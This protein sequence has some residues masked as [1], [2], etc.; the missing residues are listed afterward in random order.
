MPIAF[1]HQDLGLVDWMTVAE[2][3]AIQTGYPR[4]PLRPD[5]LAARP[6]GRGRG[7][8]EAWAAT[9]I[10]MRRSPRCRPP[11]ARSSPSAARS[12]SGRDMLVLDEPTAALPEADV[13]RLLEALRRLRAQRHRHHLRHPSPRRGVSHR[14]PRD[15]PARRPARRDGRRSRETS[16][17]SARADD[18]RPVDGGRL[19]AGPAARSE[20]VA[21]SVEAAVAE[22]VGPVSFTVAA[23]ETLGL[24]GLRGAGHHTDRPGDLRPD[25]RSSAGHMLPRRRAGRPRR[26]ADAMAQGRSA[27][28]PAAGRRRASPPTCRCARTST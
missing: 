24:V 23:G 14:R 21:L 6:P 3:V 17:G 22:R 1:I 16:P 9:S 4:C 11:S 19:R 5:L 18:R 15:G 25:A 8:G 26:P 2:N 7:A 27:S 13:E 12:R 10:R 20:R 28:S